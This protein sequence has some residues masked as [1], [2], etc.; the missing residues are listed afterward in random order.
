[1]LLDLCEA[2]V[3]SRLESCRS[4]LLDL[5]EALV[6]SRLKSCH[7]RTLPLPIL[8][9]DNSHGN[10]QDKWTNLVEGYTLM[11]RCLS[12]GCVTA[13]MDGRLLPDQLTNGAKPFPPF[14]PTIS[15]IAWVRV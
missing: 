14:P 11:T 5:C 12:L 2:L 7:A 4:V 3:S 1:M 8:N 6:S 10:L 9:L 15:H 13:Y